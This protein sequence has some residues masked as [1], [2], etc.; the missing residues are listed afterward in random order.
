MAETYWP[1]AL[2]DARITVSWLVVYIGIVVSVGIVYVDGL[3]SSEY[4]RKIGSIDVIAD[5]VS[6][7]FDQVSMMNCA[8]AFIV[9]S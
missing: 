5:S 7:W 2:R 4:L 1:V 6:M 3:I 9:T 8:S